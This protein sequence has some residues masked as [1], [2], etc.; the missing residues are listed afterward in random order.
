MSNQEPAQL[1]NDR[2]IPGSREEYVDRRWSLP[3]ATWEQL[4][5]MAASTGINFAELLVILLEDGLKLRMRMPVEASRP[6]PPPPPWS[7]V[8]VELNDKVL[9]RLKMRQVPGVDEILTVDGKSFVVRQRA[10]IVA[11][12]EAQAYLRVEEF[13]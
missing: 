1:P 6:E 2:G 8:C 3:K 7:E 13:H 9:G 4:L 5:E 12:C 10:W 11:K